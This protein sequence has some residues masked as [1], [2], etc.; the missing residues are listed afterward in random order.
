MV[1]MN[2]KNTGNTKDALE[3]M[4]QI[5]AMYKKSSNNN[6]FQKAK[7]AILKEIEQTE[8]A[9]RIYSKSLQSG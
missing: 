8:I 2:L 7:A 1:I 6:H 4:Q 5:E 3:L 9:E